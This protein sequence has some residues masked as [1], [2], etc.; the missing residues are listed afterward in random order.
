[1]SMMSQAEGTAS[2]VT[3][4]ADPAQ[5]AMSSASPDGGSASA[6][7]MDWPQAQSAEPANIRLANERALAARVARRSRLANQIKAEHPNY[8]KAEIEERLEQFG[9]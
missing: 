6:A 2:A 4:G 8:T 9:A 5:L 1:M 3:D 7:G